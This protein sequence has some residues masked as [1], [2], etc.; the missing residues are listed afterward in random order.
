MPLVTV[1][2][3]TSEGGEYTALQATPT[4]DATGKAYWVTLPAE[5]FAFPVTLSI[6][7]LLLFYPFVQKYFEKGVTI[8]AV[9]G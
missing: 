2:Y 8:G 1:N 5:A 7:P 9:K 4:R 6:L 3:Q